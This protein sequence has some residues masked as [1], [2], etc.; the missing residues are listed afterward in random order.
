MVRKLAGAALVLLVSGGLA[1]AGEGKDL[2]YVS[3]TVKS[4]S[5][6]TFT[7][8][9]DSARDW[10]FAVDGKETLVVAKGGSH[11]I[12]QLKADGKPALLSEF[13]SEKQRVDVKYF[14]KDGRMVAKKVHVKQP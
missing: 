11:K 12:D 3:G 2:K 13:V 9:D 5:G 8:T 6:S 7:V 14:E 1:L 4:V 10:T